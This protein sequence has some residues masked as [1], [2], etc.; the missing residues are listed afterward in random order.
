MLH[1]LPGAGLQWIGPRLA[2]HC[3]SLFLCCQPQNGSRPRCQCR[4]VVTAGADPFLAGRPGAL[5]PQ[6]GGR[7]QVRPAQGPLHLPQPEHRERHQGAHP[8]P[9]SSQ[10]IHGTCPPSPVRECL[11]TP[12]LQLALPLL[13]MPEVQFCALA[14]KTTRD[15]LVAVAWK[16]R[17]LSVQLA[18]QAGLTSTDRS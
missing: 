1:A 9:A 17:D 5:H 6:P 12:M 2:H 14:G 8:A 4:A 10:I 16:R 18:G 11:G 7:H 13:H 15:R 3:G